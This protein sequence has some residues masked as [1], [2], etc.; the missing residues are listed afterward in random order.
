[1]RTEQILQADILDI[2]FDNRNKDYGAYTLRKY[3]E[4]RLV[5]SFGV[6][7]LLVAIFSL[8]I[9][10]PK[11]SSKP[12]KEIITRPGYIPPVGQPEVKKKSEPEKRQKPIA[13]K[14]EGKERGTVIKIITDQPRTDI[15]STE[16]DPPLN[17][18]EPFEN[19]MQGGNEVVTTST[20][21]TSINPGEIPAIAKPDL[22]Q[23]YHAVD[24]LPSFPGGNDALARFMQANLVTPESIAPGEVI[25]VRVSFIVGYDGILKSFGIM[26]DGGAVFN[27]EVFRVLK[28]M[29]K[30]IPGK[31]AGNNVAVYFN[32]PV[33]F[34]SQQ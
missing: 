15:I 34:I 16:I 30:W 6:M 5:G 10:L 27:N 28:K 1:M 33:K 3:Y 8:N 13:K 25:T 32:I 7:M 24:V 14:R 21:N 17:V 4:N 2:I 22:N 18:T 23:V 29:P 9:F 26:E 20:P 31:A 12:D 19:N 11:G